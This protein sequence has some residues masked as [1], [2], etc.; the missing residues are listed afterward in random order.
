M[1]HFYNILRKL[2][3]SDAL[4]VKEAFPDHNGLQNAY[5]LRAS[6]LTYISETFNHPLTIMSVLF[7]TGGFF[8]GSRASEW[9]VPGSATPES[10]WDIY[11]PG[12]KES[13]ADVV[14]AFSLGGVVW[15]LGADR[16]AS[17]LAI[18]GTTT[19]SANTMRAF[20]SWIRPD[21]AKDRAIELMGKQ[22]Y[23]IIQAFKSIEHHLDKTYTISLGSQHEIHITS[24]RY[25]RG[26]PYADDETYHDPMGN[27][28]N[29]LRGSIKTKSGTQPVQ[30]IIGRHYS[31]VRG[32]MSY[33]K[34]FY[35]T[36]VQCFIG[37][38][39][40]GH[41]YYELTSRKR[42][43]LWQ[44][45]GQST[46][47]DKAVAKYKQ[48]GFM[49]SEPDAAETPVV[50]R[51]C[52]DRALL[53]DYGDIYRQFV[54]RSNHELLDRWLF[55]RRQNVDT[56]EWTEY[57]GRICSIYSP[58][59]VCFKKTV[60]TY[61]STGY[62]LPLNRLR[63][64]GDIISLTAPATDELRNKSFLSTVRKTLNDPEWQCKEVARSGTVYH[65]LHDASPWSWIM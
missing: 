18:K 31:G 27:K 26:E 19:I 55:E 24:E 4:A 57:G 5:K 64:L 43:D 52:D 14:N 36:H 1:S 63:R 8:G 35:A 20:S 47:V 11:I 40:A 61:A 10:D 65:G 29:I 17:E 30:L 42:A 2:S 37:G 16:I 38:W 9:F 22:L 32:C 44:K 13:V 56:M 15:D 53:I 3:L 23:D 58:L 41:M 46:A 59:A 28:F 54:Q 25:Q 62:N 21:V 49:F 48:R 39:C 45:L 60:K 12:Y 34:D 51:F 50:R 7:D 6:P 33:V